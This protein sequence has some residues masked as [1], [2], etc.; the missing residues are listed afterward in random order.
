M[1]SQVN[2]PSVGV[3]KSHNGSGLRNEIFNFIPGTVKQ[4]G[5]AWYSSQDQT[6]SFHKQVRFEDGT[7]SPDL[8]QAT[9]GAIPKASI[10]HHGTTNL[11]HTIDVSQIIPFM[12]GT[13]QD[14]ATI[15]AEVSAAAVAQASK[16]FCGMGEHKITKLK[17]GYLAD[18]ELIF[19]SWCTDILVHIHD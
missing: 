4:Q 5:M 2:L 12:S 16:E 10:P 19:C 6:F 1:A 18:T 14:A 11:N 17:G 8:N 15:A 13:H 7:S 9:S 3:T